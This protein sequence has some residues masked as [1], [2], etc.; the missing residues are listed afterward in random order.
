MD[1]DTVCPSRRQT[2]ETPPALPLRSHALQK[3][4]RRV[5]RVK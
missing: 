3:E 5:K 2:L 4:R 1:D